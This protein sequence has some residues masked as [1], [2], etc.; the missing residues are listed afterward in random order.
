[1]DDFFPISSRKAGAKEAGRVSLKVG[2]EA[3][4][5]GANN[6]TGSQSSHVDVSSESDDG[7]RPQAPPPPADAPHN[8][9]KPSLTLSSK[10]KANDDK[11][12]TSA[13]VVVEEDDIVHTGG[14]RMDDDPQFNVIPK[15]DDDVLLG[16]TEQV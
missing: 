6:P 8:D 12:R 4:L 1:M 11:L 10:W 9:A 14:L 13:V 3:A 7:D 5:S 15:M 2:S 16:A